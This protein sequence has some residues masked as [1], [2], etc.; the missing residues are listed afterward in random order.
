MLLFGSCFAQNIGRL[1]T[2]NKFRCDVN[3]FGVLYNPFS[4]LEAIEEI[5]SGKQYDKSGLVFHQEQWHSL[6]HHSSFSDSSPERCLANINGRLREASRELACADY[7][8]ITFGTA[9]VYLHKESGRVA[10][11]CHKL[12]ESAFDRR[13]LGADEIAGRFSACIS[14]LLQVRP[15]LKLLFTVSPIRHVKDSMHGNQLSKSVLHLSI[16]RLKELFPENVF[17]FP[18]YEIL[19]DELRDYRFYADDMLHPS[20]LSVAY[21]WECFVNSY[22]SGQTVR[23]MREWA[24]IIKALNHKPFDSSSEKYKSFLTQ[25]VL[26]IKR[27]KEKYP[28]LDVEKELELC[29]ILLRQ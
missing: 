15:S 20:S 13:M 29:H 5:R 19:I 27:V 9:F 23:I 4:I 16:H 2:E 3:P 11:N 10:G 6:M 21:I 1:L 17:Y 7:L 28:N 25:N 24:D 26:R 22:F 8:L 12:P 14:S 18:S